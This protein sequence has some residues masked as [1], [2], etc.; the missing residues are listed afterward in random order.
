[1]LVHGS[2]TNKSVQDKRKI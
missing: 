2:L 1:M